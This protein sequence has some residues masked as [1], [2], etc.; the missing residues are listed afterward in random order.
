MKKAIQIQ[1]S[2]EE[3]VEWTRIAKEVIITW[4]LPA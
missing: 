4:P 2:E 1:D 3:C